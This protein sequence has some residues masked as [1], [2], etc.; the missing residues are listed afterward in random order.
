M[1]LQKVTTATP[2][3]TR[4]LPPYRIHRRLQPVRTSSI[5]RSLPDKWALPVRRRPACTISSLL[6]RRRSRMPCSTPTRDTAGSRR[7]HREAKRP[8]HLPFQAFSSRALHR[9]LYTSRCMRRRRSIWRTMESQLLTLELATSFS[10]NRCTAAAGDG[11]NKPTGFMVWTVKRC[12]RVFD[13]KE[14]F[15]SCLA[16]YWFRGSLVKH[17][18]D[19]RGFLFLETGL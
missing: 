1:V 12:S 15:T 18:I 4:R 6:S 8:R 3:T 2:I 5:S 7:R 19:F 14:T 16:S 13:N 11:E 9:R 17:F 10:G